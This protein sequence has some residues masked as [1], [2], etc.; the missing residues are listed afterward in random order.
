MRSGGAELVQLGALDD[1]PAVVQQQPATPDEG[2]VREV[3]REEIGL[4]ARLIRDE[5]FPAVPGATQCRDC[6]L[7]ADLSGEERR[8]GGVR[9]NASAR[10]SARRRSSRR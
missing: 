7:R 1:G 5:V 8:F 2:P 10:R 3:L 9:M 4:T 6:R